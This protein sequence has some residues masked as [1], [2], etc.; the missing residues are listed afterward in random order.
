MFIVLSFLATAAATV[1]SGCQTIISREAFIAGERAWVIPKGMVNPQAMDP[2]HPIKRG[3]PIYL[4]LNFENIGREPAVDFQ[5]YWGADIYPVSNPFAAP[6]DLKFL[7]PG[8]YDTYPKTKG[9]VIFPSNPMT[10]IAPVNKEKDVATA[11]LDGTG[12]F[13]VNFCFA[14]RT[15]TIVHRTG[16]CFYLHIS[17]NTRQ[18]QW[19]EC[20]G[21]SSA[22]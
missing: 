6:D 18:P 15:I 17:A 12:V 14:Y 20:P 2:P 13:Y 5:R 8:C 10:F 22:N 19:S 11:V 3:E 4:Q 1:F 9:P 16:F 21:G 7:D